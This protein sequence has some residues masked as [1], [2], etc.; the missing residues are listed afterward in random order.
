MPNP[1]AVTATSLRERITLS[2]IRALCQM[3]A[4]F[5]LSRSVPPGY[6][7]RQAFDDT[8]GCPAEQPNAVA[9]SGM[10]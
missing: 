2:V 4:I 8:I 1:H 7:T 9:N 6:Q 3:R 5:P 10:F